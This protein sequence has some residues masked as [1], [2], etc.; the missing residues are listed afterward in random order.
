VSAEDPP[1]E[2][3]ITLSVDA[4]EAPR[5]ILHAKLVIP[6]KP[7]PLTLFYPK[8]IPG[9]H[10]PTGPISDLAGLRLAADGKPI[11]WRRDDADMYA[12]SCEVPAGASEIT[13]TLDF[14]APPSSG[15]R[16]S[17][18][19]SCSAKLAVL[20]WN[21]F[22]LYPKG[23][24]PR[25]LKFQADVIV[26]RDWKIA[27]AL[28][29]LSGPGE[30]T[31]FAPVSLETLIDSP[32]LCGAYLKDVPIG[33]TDAPR[34]YLHVAADSPEA[35]RI[36]SAMQSRFDA[37][38]AEAG[39]MFGCRPYG[40][41]HFL[42]ALSDHVAHF[43]LEHHQ[44]SDNRA[45]E[46]L[47]LDD[48]IMLA[49]VDL[50]PHEYVHSWNGKYRRPRDMVTKD[51]Q[52]PQK[53][54]LLWIYEGLTD[55]LDM[56]LATR[57]GLCSADDFNDSLALYAQYVRNMR[58][59]AWRPLDDTGAAFQ[60][61]DS[62]RMD[63][64]VWRRSAW[65][66]YDEG[67]MVWLETD[68]IIRTES[69]GRRS[70][71]DFCRRLFGGADEAP[72]VKPYAI[73]DVVADLNAVAPYD[74]AAFFQ[75]R[76][77]EAANQAPLRGIELGGW[78][79][80]Y[81]STPSY[82]QQAWDSQWSGATDLSASIGVSVKDDGVIVDVIPGEPADR[83]GLAPGVKIVAVN[84]RRFS[85]ERLCSAIASSEDSQAPLELLT[86]NA[87][88]FRTCTLDYHDG[89]KY[90]LLERNE[91]M[92]DLLREIVKPLSGLTPPGAG[93]KR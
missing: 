3:A 14:L 82:L 67:A 61:F 35:I 7:G 57:S 93:N 26:P 73:E 48:T 34:H 45:P 30:R 31:T 21:Q 80:A 28:P 39:A 13:A 40:S 85:M 50:L 72:S 42:L 60:L 66:V 55:Y 12:F 16:F 68:C 54:R 38:V 36:D 81:D 32:V 78:K 64:G 17:A 25:E 86:E 11:P 75:Q 84:M 27:T 20:N 70:L 33:P 63:W 47:F 92:P 8:W 23:A 65:D 1:K 37:L 79:L 5:R 44:C 87:D 10:G 53:T 89:E 88:Y 58:G 90:P 51:Y 69:K 74:W 77:A 56:V 18:G 71:N 9:E 22:V 59:R 41:Y 76:T 19:P 49:T 83:A 52:E 15:G 43:G 46:R 29:V 4:T 91:S 24:D 62:G 6:A 2:P